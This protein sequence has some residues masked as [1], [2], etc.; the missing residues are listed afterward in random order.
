MK[1]YKKLIGNSG[2]D[3]A[4]TYLIQN[5]YSIINRNV[6]CRYGEIDII[7]MKEGLVVFVEVKTLPSGS[8]EILALELGVRKQ[9]R[10]IE[11]AKYFLLN[12]RK[13]N[14]SL[15]RFDAVIIDMP[16]FPPVYHIENAFSEIL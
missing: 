12:N 15:I 14:N 6:H 2:E 13:Y 3:R 11:T 7:A 5:G 1:K 10:I 4:C 9:K 8:P 16:G